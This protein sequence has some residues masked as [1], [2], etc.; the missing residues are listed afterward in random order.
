MQLK[1]TLRPN[2]SYSFCKQEKT[3]TKSI[4]LCGLIIFI[5]LYFSDE[6]VNGIRNIQKV[7]KPNPRKDKPRGGNY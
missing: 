7:A 1:N 5:L 2:P 6:D 4:I 3:K